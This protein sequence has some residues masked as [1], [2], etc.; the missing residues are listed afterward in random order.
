MLA[1]QLLL[2]LLRL[3]LCL[4]GWRDRWTLARQLLLLRRLLHILPRWL[5]RLYRLHILP[6]RRRR[7]RRRGLHVLTG[8]LRRRR[9]L[10]VLAR[11]L[12]WRC[13]LRAGR[14]WRRRRLYVWS[15]RRLL[16][17]A[18]LLLLGRR[19]LDQN[20]GRIAYGRIARCVPWSNASPAR[21]ARRSNHRGARPG[22]RSRPIRARACTR[23]AM[24]SRA[25][26]TSK[27]AINK[28]RLA[29]I[30]ISPSGPRPLIETLERFASQDGPEAA[31]RRH[32]ASAIRSNLGRWVVRFGEKSSG[33]NRLPQGFA[34]SVRWMRVRVARALPQ[35]RA[36]A[37]SWR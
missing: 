37:A 13:R 19:R 23:S 31:S 22:S 25:F 32:P 21:A 2:L 12:R 16:L 24:R 33:F 5:G 36:G 28:G 29:I 6:W 20:D 9:G 30:S 35:W 27:L 1:R 18:L 11:R 17:L 3:R 4:S 14:L 8:R 34:L 7:R 15:S 26:G 10:H